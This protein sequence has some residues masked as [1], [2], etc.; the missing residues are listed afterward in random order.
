MVNII[1]T[2]LIILIVSIFSVQNSA[3]V[4]ITFLVWQFQASLA[5]VIFL[6]VLSGVIIGVALAFLY[7]I[8]RQRQAR[9]KNS[10]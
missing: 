6:C 9:L 5:I 4:A 1:I 10:E 3:P 8:K 7:R 2:I